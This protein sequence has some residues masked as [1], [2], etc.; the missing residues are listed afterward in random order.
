MSSHFLIKLMM[1]YLWLLVALDIWVTLI[2]LI[3]CQIIHSIDRTGHMT[4]LLVY[5]LPQIAVSND[6]LIPAWQGHKI[7]RT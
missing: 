3:I 4:A 7:E 6:R 5:W 1:H 2:E